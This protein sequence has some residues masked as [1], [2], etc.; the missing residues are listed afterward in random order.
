M[1]ESYN[2][3]RTYF[4]DHKMM[5]PDKLLV[6]ENFKSYL[7]LNRFDSHNQLKY[8]DYFKSQEFTDV[9]DDHEQIFV[10]KLTN[11][12]KLFRKLQRSEYDICL[13]FIEAV[14]FHLYNTV[15]LSFYLIE[16][17]ENEYDELNA[18]ISNKI[19]AYKKQK[20][21]L[22]ND[23]NEAFTNDSTKNLE[24]LLQKIRQFFKKQKNM[25]ANDRKN[26]Q[27][28]FRDK[29]QLIQL[30]FGE[31]FYRLYH[32]WT[33]NN[34]RLKLT[35]DKMELVS[36]LIVRITIEVF[37][38][39]GSSKTGEFSGFLINKNPGFNAEN[40]DIVAF[41][42]VFTAYHCFIN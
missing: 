18:Q 32:I 41:Y 16:V 23:K 15:D 38:K 30:R 22:E 34:L 36:K 11:A 10:P 42:S 19:D 3:C 28:E 40:S 12:K 2:K 20:A 27:T 1:Y 6:F 24:N 29:V 31:E 4:D 14:I 26:E 9:F 17:F 8:N 25:K 5:C 39:K 7:F 33:D 37:D 35:K 13:P 21:D